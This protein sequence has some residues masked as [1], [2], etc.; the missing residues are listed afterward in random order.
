MHTQSQACSTML[1]SL[2]SNIHII[3]FNCQCA[4]LSLLVFVVVFFF[5]S[6]RCKTRVYSLICIAFYWFCSFLTNKISHLQAQLWIFFLKFEY[7]MTTFGA[8]KRLS[9]GWM[10]LRAKNTSWNEYLR[11]VAILFLLLLLYVHNIYVHTA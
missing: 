11:I 9:I 2:F 5:F 8:Q 6:K 7:S 4:Q 3:S 1:S 10:L